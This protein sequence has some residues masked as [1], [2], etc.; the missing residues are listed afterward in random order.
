MYIFKAI[1]DYSEH[2][3]SESRPSDETHTVWP[4]SDLHLRHNNG[5]PDGKIRLERKHRGGHMKPV[6]VRPSD[7]RS[8]TSTTCAVLY[9]SEQ[10]NNGTNKTLLPTRGGWYI[11]ASRPHFWHPHQVICCLQ[12]S[13]SLGLLWNQRW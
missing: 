8:P 10:H 2:N 5:T 4:V 7:R 9:N 11:W 13:A 1:P 3:D 6:R 12:M